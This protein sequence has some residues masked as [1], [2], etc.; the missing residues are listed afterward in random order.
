MFA[1]SSF[2]DIS[3]CTFPYIYLCQHRTL[4]TIAHSSVCFILRTA[5]PEIKKWTFKL[6]RLVDT[7]SQP[8]SSFVNSQPFIH[9]SHLP[10]IVHF[11]IMHLFLLCFEQDRAH[12]Y[13]TQFLH[14]LLFHRLNQ[15]PHP[16]SDFIQ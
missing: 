13:R 2:P 16:F 15:D 4:R 12:E 5:M 1:R 11:L 8:F 7:S 6:T 10:F 3:N 9:V 14:Y